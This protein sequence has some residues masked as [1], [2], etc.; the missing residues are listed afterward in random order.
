MT[1]VREGGCGLPLVDWRHAGE[2]CL[3]TD[4]RQGKLYL[5]LASS[6]TLYEALHRIDLDL[7][8]Q[9][10]AAGCPWC[11]DPLDYGRWSRQP[12]GCD[13]PDALKIRHGLCCRREGCRRRTTPP[14]TLFQGRRVYWSAV[15]LVS[16]LVRQRRLEGRS[17]R[18]LRLRFGVTHRTLLRW[19]GWFETAQARTRGWRTL[20]GLVPASVSDRELP[21]SLL[22]ALEGKHGA[23]SGA[24][25]ACLRLLSGAAEACFARGLSPPQK[26]PDLVR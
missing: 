19:I 10:K 13:L 25:V 22:A 5:D 14:S 2:P 8:E 4:S 3:N 12:R 20:R 17:A 18:A 9:T 11:G 1:A 16:V 24:L 7:A 21:S 6:A 15:I 26:L 23:G